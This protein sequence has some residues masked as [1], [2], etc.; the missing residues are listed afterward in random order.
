MK[1]RIVDLKPDGN[2]ALT[3]TAMMQV[4]AMQN[5][6]RSTAR[7]ALE[8]ELYALRAG[9][10]DLVASVITFDP[11]DEAKVANL[12]SVVPVDI[13]NQ[14]RTPES[15]VAFLFMG[16]QRME[17]LG[18]LAETASRDDVV[19]QQ[20]QFKFFDDPEI[21]KEAF[22]FFRDPGGWK[23]VVPTA[24]IERITRTIKAQPSK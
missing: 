17:A 4:K 19:V 20:I 15:I 23:N 18:I 9:D 14:Y 12:L 6:G 24:L 16:G 1:E 13:R 10:V 22:P 5:V 3:G 8:T 7:A 2:Y 11:A 21:R